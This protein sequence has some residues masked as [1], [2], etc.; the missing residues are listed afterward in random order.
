MTRIDLTD[1][2]SIHDYRSLLKLQNDTGKTRTLENRKGLRCPACDRP[3]DRLF[4]TERA[5]HSFESP[6]DRPFCLANTAEKV[7]VLTH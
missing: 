6:P 1:G 2:F 7:L 4:V 3:F 5:T